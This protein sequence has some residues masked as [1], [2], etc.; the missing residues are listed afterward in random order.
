MSDATDVIDAALGVAEGSKL[1]MLRAARPEARARTQSSYAALFDPAEPGALTRAERFGAALRVAELEEAG[2][3]AAHYRARLVGE[4]PAVRAAA[5]ARHVELLTRSPSA[6]TRAD[7]AKLAEAGLTSPE[8]VTL[9]QIVAFVAYQ[10][11]VVA[12]LAL[13]GGTP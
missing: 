2:S 13:I 4:T 6:A 7:L 12:S 9:S 11:R 5:I 1:D 3:L 8:I 10:V